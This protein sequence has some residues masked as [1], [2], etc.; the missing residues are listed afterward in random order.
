MLKRRKR[1]GALASKWDQ[2]SPFV[3]FGAD[4]PGTHR[5]C[6]V[7]LLLPVAL[8]PPMGARAADFFTKAAAPHLCDSDFAVV[9]FRVRLGRLSRTVHVLH[10]VH[11]PRQR[12]YQSS[13]SNASRVRAISSVMGGRIA[14]FLPAVVPIPC[15]G[16]RPGAGLVVLKLLRCRVIQSG[17]PAP[18]AA[19]CVCSGATGCGFGGGSCPL[20]FL[21]IPTISTTT[22]SQGL[23]FLTLGQYRIAACPR[24]LASGRFAAQVSIA[25]GTGSASTDRVMRFHDDFA[26]R[27]A[28]ADYA[29]AQGIDWVNDV[30]RPRTR[31]GAPSAPQIC[32]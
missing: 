22:P 9:H 7:Q 29:V 13:P 17:T 21:M 3:R 18:G 8:L 12:G 15:C 31:P 27:D 24:P 25:S 19:T 26:T 16:S 2:H 23:S 5:A 6:R 4:R 11:R 28:A 20:M 1:G 14:N 32:I 30:L 10:A